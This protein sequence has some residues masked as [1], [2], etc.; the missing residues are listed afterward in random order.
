M[1]VT[2]SSGYCSTSTISET[3]KEVR[4]MVIHNR[5]VG[6]AEVAQNLIVS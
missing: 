5:A 1:T 3:L 6:I 2:E 4:A